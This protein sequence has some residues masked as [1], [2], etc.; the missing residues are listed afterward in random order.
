MRRPEQ[1]SIKLMLNGWRFYFYSSL[2]HD[3][4]SHDKSRFTCSQSL[5]GL[6]SNPW[7][8]LHEKELHLIFSQDL[9][10]VFQ[11]LLGLLH[12]QEFLTLHFVQVAQCS[13]VL[14]FQVL[15]WVQLSRVV[16][17]VLKGLVQPDLEGRIKPSIIRGGKCAPHKFHFHLLSI[18]FIDEDKSA[19][20]FTESQVSTWFSLKSR[21][22]NKPFEKVRRTSNQ[23][24]NIHVSYQ[25]I[26][27]AEAHLPDCAPLALHLPNPHITRLDNSGKPGH[28]MFSD[29]LYV[30]TFFVS[31]CIHIQVLPAPKM[32]SDLLTSDPANLLIF[33]FEF[34]L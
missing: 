8:L 16:P 28:V 33:R 30:F 20:L 17:G 31:M 21:K 19:F 4:S 27:P 12:L 3:S 6:E 29:L 11:V 10:L 23:R 13:W 32:H 25:S 34:C 18:W 5:S 24:N 2:I 14:D 1:Q 15:L 22:T 9:Y 26:L 7:T